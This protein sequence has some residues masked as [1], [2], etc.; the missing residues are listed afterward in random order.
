M[1]GVSTSLRSLGCFC[2]GVR[3]A[4]AGAPR[5]GPGAYHEA[6]SLKLE[7]LQRRMKDPQRFQAIGDRE[8]R[9]SISPQAIRAITAGKYLTFYRGCD[10]FKVPEDLSILYQMFWHVRPRTVLELGSYNGGSALW[11]ADAL[12]GAN[13]ECSVFSMDI[14]LSLLHPQIKSIQLP[15]LSFIQGDCN[16]LQEAFPPEFLSAQP[17]LLL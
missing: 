15:N 3:F 14:D 17:H 16:K 12:N 7:L 2:L 6:M 1:A 5:K 11:M 9:S 8:E 13:I 4:R 10:M